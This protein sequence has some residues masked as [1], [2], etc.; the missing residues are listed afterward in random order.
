MRGEAAGNLRRGRGK[1][2]GDFGHA[3]HLRRENGQIERMQGRQPTTHTGQQ[4][5]AVRTRGVDGNHARH[6]VALGARVFREAGNHDVGERQNI[7]GGEADATR[8][9]E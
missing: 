4:L 1:T 7:D 8:V 3:A 2:M 5:D 9:K 6:D